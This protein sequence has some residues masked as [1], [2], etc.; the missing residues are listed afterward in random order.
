MNWQTA[1]FC[2][3]FYSAL[4]F[5]ISKLNLPQA[6]AM[7]IK[8]K[9][10]F[11]TSRNLNCAISKNGKMREDEEKELFSAKVKFAVGP[12]FRVRQTYHYLRMCTYA[13]MY[14]CKYLHAFAVHPLL[15]TLQLCNYV[16]PE[17]LLLTGHSITFNYKTFRPTV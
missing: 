3:Q 15:S 6:A 1:T 9:T 14:V 8:T 4:P 12:F 16:S 2:C 11:I 5:V 7:K 13:H 10:V 17:H